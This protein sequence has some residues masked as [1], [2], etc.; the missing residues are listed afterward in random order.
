MGNKITVLGWLTSNMLE[1]NFTNNPNL[2]WEY[3]GNKIIYNNNINTE[4]V[5]TREITTKRH[6]YMK[7]HMHGSE[8]S[9]SYNLNISDY[10]SSLPYCSN[11]KLLTYSGSAFGI[12][13]QCVGAYFLSD[14]TVISM[15]AYFSY[16]ELLAFESDTLYPVARYR[17]KGR[18]S[19]MQSLLSLDFNA[20]VKDVTGGV[21]LYIDNCDRI[22]VGCSDITI[23]IFSYC[24]EQKEFILQSKIY[25]GKHMLN[26]VSLLPDYNNRLWVTDSYGTVN[27]V[28]NDL[29]VKTFKLGGVIANSIAISSDYVYVLNDKMLYAFDSNKMTLTW[30]RRY[31][32]VDYLKPGMLS[33]GSGSTPTIL[34]NYVVITDNA[35]DYIKANFYDK[36]NG[37]LIKSVSVPFKKDHGATECSLVGV[38]DTQVIIVNNYGYTTFAEVNS[39]RVRPLPGVCMV[40][41]SEEYKDQNYIQWMSCECPSTSLPLVDRQRQFLYLYTF[42]LECETKTL[43]RFAITILDVNSGITVKKI[44]TGFG[45]GFDNHWSP[46]HLAPDGTAYIGTIN[47]MMRAIPC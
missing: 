42:D 24:K 27:I 22:I 39:L 34:D 44:R 5:K 31:E 13:G 12:G 19:D 25:L 36:D 7:S 8:Y 35:H 45:V 16:F 46:L 33:T 40:N 4:Q 14:G 18:K 32:K 1:K 6:P 26:I 23:R 47:G 17:L 9:S 21:Y 41:I 37:N 3:S 30:C 11:V 29:V 43:T 2:H 38:S 20:I 28:D 10:S 15:C